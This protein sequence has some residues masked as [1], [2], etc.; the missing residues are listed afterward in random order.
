MCVISSQITGN[1]AGL[2]QFVLSTTKK[3]WQLCITGYLW[4]NPPVTVGFPSQRTSYVSSYHDVIMQCKLITLLSTLLR[5]ISVTQLASKN[6]FKRHGNGI[7]FPSLQINFHVAA[8]TLIG[9]IGAGAANF[10]KW[11]CP[12]V[13]IN[14]A[15][16]I[17]FFPSDLQ[18]AVKYLPLVLHKCI[19]KLSK[20]WFG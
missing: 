2:Q 9:N 8:V 16:Y 14:E 6:S 15:N 20:H 11:L 5:N 13:D 1:S 3:P 10:I 4:G 12:F 17:S 18:L 7:R 19:S